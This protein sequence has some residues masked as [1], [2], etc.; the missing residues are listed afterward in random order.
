MPTTFFVKHGKPIGTTSFEAGALVSDSGDRRVTESHTASWQIEFSDGVEARALLA[1][2][3][4]TKR[5][6]ARDVP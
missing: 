5:V 2:V 4:A 1:E 3:I 6:E